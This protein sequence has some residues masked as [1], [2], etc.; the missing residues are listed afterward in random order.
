MPFLKTKENI[1]QAFLYVSIQSLSTN[2]FS[3]PQ[4]SEKLVQ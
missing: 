4:T 1:L 3:S 2:D